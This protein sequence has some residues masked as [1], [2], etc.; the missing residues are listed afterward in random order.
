[1]TMQPCELFDRLNNCHYQK[2][3]SLQ[4]RQFVTR[5]ALFRSNAKTFKQ[6]PIT[7]VSKAIKIIDH[8]MGSCP[9]CKGRTIKRTGVHFD[10]Q[11]R[12]VVCNWIGE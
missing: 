6:D 3:L 1:M 12:C 2:A 11:R 10:H 4:L 5:N 9:C 7:C 8:N